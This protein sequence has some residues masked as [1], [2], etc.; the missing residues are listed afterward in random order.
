MSFLCSSVTGAGMGRGERLGAGG[1]SFLLFPCTL[2]LLFLRK[3]F[4][5]G[6]LWMEAGGVGLEGGV[7]DERTATLP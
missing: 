2:A 3:A 5:E 6:C 4:Q 7:G 1:A